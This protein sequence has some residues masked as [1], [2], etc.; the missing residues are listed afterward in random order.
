MGL[1]SYQQSRSRYDYQVVTG[2]ESGVR[3]ADGR[4]GRLNDCTKVPGPDVR[5]RTP[6]ES[7]DLSAARTNV[8]V[9][10]IYDWRGNE[11]AIAREGPPDCPRVGIARL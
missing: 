11:G 3:P 1:I 7:V 5:T 2:A 4:L 8:Y 9:A 10:V 6:V